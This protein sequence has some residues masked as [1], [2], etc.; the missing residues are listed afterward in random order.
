MKEREL[1]ALE[2]N[3]EALDVYK[4]PI[5][6]DTVIKKEMLPYLEKDHR[7]ILGGLS[8][9]IVRNDISDELVYALTKTVYTNLPKLANE[10]PY[11]KY[12]VKYA[13]ILTEDAGIP[14]HPGAIKYWKE[15]GVWNR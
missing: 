9:F 12:P 11:W 8:S 2:W 6:P 5:F 15:V 10:N 3:K 14:Y 1:V 7:G 13:S 4:N